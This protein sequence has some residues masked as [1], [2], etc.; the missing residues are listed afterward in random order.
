VKHLI[1]LTRMET[2]GRVPNCHVFAISDL[3]MMN[4]CGSDCREAGDR[5]GWNS[6]AVS[7]SESNRGEGERN[8]YLD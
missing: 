2:V 8:L 7:W 1:C 3:T 4:M 6:D 5:A